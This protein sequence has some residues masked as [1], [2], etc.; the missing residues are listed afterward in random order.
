[1]N[2]DEVERKLRRDYHRH[3]RWQRKILRYC[4]PELDPSREGAAAIFATLESFRNHVVEADKLYGAQID[5]AIASHRKRKSSRQSEEETTQPPLQEELS[6][7]ESIGKDCVE[8]VRHLKA[9]NHRHKMFFDAKDVVFER[10]HYDTF[11]VAEFESRNLLVES[12][13]PAQ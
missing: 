3:V 13:T 5:A 10:A 11:L 4:N 12:Q 7:I 8:A 9:M 6:V 2:A 1:M